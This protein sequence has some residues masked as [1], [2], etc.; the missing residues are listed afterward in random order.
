MC[1]AGRTD[2]NGLPRQKAADR[3]YFYE[4]KYKHKTR[5]KK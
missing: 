5:W 3:F 4:I 2:K 1:A